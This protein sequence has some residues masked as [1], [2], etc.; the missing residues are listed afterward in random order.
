M[1]LAGSQL[2]FVGMNK[3]RAKRKSQMIWAAR[4]GAA[5]MKVW[6]SQPIRTIRSA[7]RSKRLKAKAAMMRVLMDARAN[8][9]TERSLYQ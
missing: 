3:A 7:P 2:G 5:S 4:E 1:S 6:Q 8:G 9:F